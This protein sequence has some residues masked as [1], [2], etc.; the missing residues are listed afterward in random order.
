MDKIHRFDR[1]G[2]GNFTDK[3]NKKT[4]KLSL[5]THILVFGIEK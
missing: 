1:A 5:L 2:L 4:L 3:N